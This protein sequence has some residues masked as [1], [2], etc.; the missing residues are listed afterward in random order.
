MLKYLLSLYYVP[1]TECQFM[2]AAAS[3]E[4]GVLCKDISVYEMGNPDC[5]PY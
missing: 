4:A 5:A 2:R 3:N 1:D